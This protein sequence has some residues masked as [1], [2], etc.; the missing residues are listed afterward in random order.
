MLYKEI[1]AFNDDDV[2]MIQK[3]VFTL[4][5]PLTATKVNLPVKTIQCQH[6][7]CFDLENFC[8]FN[9]IP[10]GVKTLLRKDLVK[11]NYE[12]KKQ[13]R[14][15]K[16]KYGHNS[17]PVNI[18]QLTK[19][20]GVSSKAPGYKC[21]ICN[22]DFKL[23]QLFISDVFNYFVKTTPKSIDRIEL[24]DMIKYRIVEDDEV[25]SVPEEVIELGDETNESDGGDETNQSDDSDDNDEIKLP[26][27]SSQRSRIKLEDD[28][29]FDQI[30]N[31]IS[32]NNNDSDDIF[33]DD[34]ELIRTIDQ[35]C[36]DTNGGTE[37]KP[38]LTA[39][40]NWGEGAG[41]WDDPVVL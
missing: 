34:S 23:V 33:T 4:R 37:K 12:L 22:C 31:V 19:A 17:N 11:R 41:S 25:E 40:Q 14:L 1:G 9:H 30:N 39:G 16:Q 36:G 35:V 3:M 29:L 2:N 32:Q 38:R 13:E 28:T 15:Y 26:K 10:K 6:F 18:I 7:E 27:K 8:T 20:N 21:P 5:D 24:R